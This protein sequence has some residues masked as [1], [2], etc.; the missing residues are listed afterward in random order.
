MTDKPKIN[1]ILVDTEEA[2]EIL[3]GHTD[4]KAKKRLRR[5]AQSRKISHIKD[6]NKFWFNR[7]YLYKIAN[8]T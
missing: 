6:G 3:F 1:S 8:D 7:R 2:S 4:E 5:L